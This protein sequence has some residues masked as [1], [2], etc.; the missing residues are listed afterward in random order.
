[1][2]IARTSSHNTGEVNT[3]SAETHSVRQRRNSVGGVRE[4]HK[5]STRLSSFTV[6]KSGAKL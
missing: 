3:S 4:L 5:I 1:M 2:K 6:Y